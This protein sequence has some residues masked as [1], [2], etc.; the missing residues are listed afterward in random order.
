MAAMT[1]AIKTIALYP[2][3]NGFELQD[4][5]GSNA[6]AY[7]AS[8]CDLGQRQ[9][10]SAGMS[11]R[12]FMAPGDKAVYLAHAFCGVWHWRHRQSEQRVSV[13]P[14]TQSS[15][16]IFPAM[17]QGCKSQK[18]KDCFYWPIPNNPTGTFLS[19]DECDFLAGLP[20]GNSGE[21][22]M[23]PHKYLPARKSALRRRSKCAGRIIGNWA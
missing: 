12:A 2:D 15:D 19:A 23:N 17:L 1:E 18:S 13:W 16:M 10:R 11:S 21:C 6:T 8:T 4:A 20:P 22:W 5:A 7:H 14:A 9:Q 3:G